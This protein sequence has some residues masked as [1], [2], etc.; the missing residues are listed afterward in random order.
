[1]IAVISLLF[2]LTTLAFAF[3][4]TARMASRRAFIGYVSFYAWSFWLSL[5]IFILINLGI[6][7][8]AADLNT[9]L[10]LQSA[11]LGAFEF[12]YAALIIFGLLDEAGAKRKKV[13]SRL[14]LIGGLLGWF[15]P[16]LQ[17][18]AVF[19]A[20]EVVLTL[21]LAKSRS[22]R[23]YLWRAHVKSMAALPLLVGFSLPAGPVF[24]LYILW[25]AAFKRSAVNAA[26]VKDAMLDYDETSENKNAI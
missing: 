4:A 13:L 26:V 17:V 5:L 18:L 25:T 3:V 22:K 7:S 23:R 9:L 19:A 12:A 16:P 10:R 20:V 6:F 11:M 1:M 21:A 24:L 15:L 8:D 14:P 2:S